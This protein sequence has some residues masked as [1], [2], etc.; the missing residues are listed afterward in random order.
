MSHIDEEVNSNIIDTIA[1]NF[2]ELTVTKEKKL[3]GMDIDFLGNGKVSLFMKDY[4]E[5]SIELFNEDLDA[6]V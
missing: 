4:I 5:E 6:T 1:E 2:G 3:L